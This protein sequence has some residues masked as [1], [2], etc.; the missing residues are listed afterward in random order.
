MADARSTSGTGWATAADA[1]AERVT[2]RDRLGTVLAWVGR[3]LLVASIAA[4]TNAARMLPPSC[5]TSA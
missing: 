1:L 5:R 4:P 3:G 2:R